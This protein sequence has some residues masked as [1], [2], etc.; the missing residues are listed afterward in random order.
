MARETFALRVPIEVGIA[1]DRDRPGSSGEE[2]TREVFASVERVTAGI[3]L[4]GDHAPA[5][6]V[7][8][9][10]APVA[11]G[12]RRPPARRTPITYYSS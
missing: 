3:P 11:R 1:C 10:R 2:A 7:D 5:P 6:V 4:P 9:I 8:E 12:P